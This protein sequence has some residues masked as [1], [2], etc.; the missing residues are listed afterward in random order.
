MAA[1]PLAAISV[2]C[3]PW[4][5]AMSAAAAATVGLLN[6]EYQV[7]CSPPVPWMSS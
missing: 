6:R 3:A 4:S 1:M 5:R 7:S 2:C